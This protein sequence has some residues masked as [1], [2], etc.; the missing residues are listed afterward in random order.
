MELVLIGVKIFT[1]EMYK[2]KVYNKYGDKL[3]VISE[4]T[5]SLNK[6]TVKH[7]CDIHG[8]QIKTLN[9]KNVFSKSFCLCPVCVELARLESIRKPK[10]SSQDM[11]DKLNTYVK[12]ND[13]ILINTEWNT[14][15]GYY[16]VKCKN[17]HTFT[18]TAD[19][20]LNKKQWCPYCSG[21]K[22]DFNSI[23]NDHIIAKDGI[24]MS[25]YVNG[26]THISVKCNKHNYIW[27]ILPCNI[28]KGR[29]CP[30]CSLPYSEKVMFDYLIDKGLK[31]RVQYKFSDLKSNKGEYLRFDFAI[32]DN[33]DNLLL[34]IEVDDKEHR[35]NPKEERRIISMNRDVI[36]NNYCNDNNIQLARVVFDS[37]DKEI[38][39]Y[40]NYYKYIDNKIKYIISEV[41]S[42]E[43]I[44]S[45]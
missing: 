17:G 2:E 8:I 44:Q 20:L 9:A 6:I 11:F 12:D 43:Y 13:G 39:I 18:T 1:T 3:E 40:D 14:Y 38:K 16:T 27:D 31:V 5:G 22:G 23:Y 28:T 7:N 30:V 32:L 25:E 19:S 36:K 45:V 41:N 35:G 24:M 10:P 37:F 4:Y 42:S 33:N 29:W 34:L 15:K 26:K 21:R